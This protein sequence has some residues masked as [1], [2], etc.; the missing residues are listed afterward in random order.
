MFILRRDSTN[1]YWIATSEATGSSYDDVAEAWHS[2]PSAAFLER[3][4]AALI[5]GPDAPRESSSLEPAPAFVPAFLS[6]L[7]R[8]SDRLTMGWA[9][10]CATCGV[11]VSAYEPPPDFT[12]SLRHHT[13]TCT[14]AKDKRLQR[15]VWLDTAWTRHVERIRQLSRS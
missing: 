3:L 12:F 2:I 8:E 13:R 15:D 6:V 14:A 4:R 10:T 5:V 7:E 1:R 9:G 11:L